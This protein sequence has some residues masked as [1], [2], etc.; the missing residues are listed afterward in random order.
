[1]VPTPTGA[2]MAQRMT[3]L[4]A[5]A[6]EHER[7]GNPSLASAAVLPWMMQFTTFAVVPLT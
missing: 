5:A 3:L 2:G 1:M 6:V 4:K 7:F